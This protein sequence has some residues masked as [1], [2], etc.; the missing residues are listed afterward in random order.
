M[1]RGAGLVV[2]SCRGG[3]EAELVIGRSGVGGGK[4][5]GAWREGR[6]M[7]GGLAPALGCGLSVW[8]SA[9][10]RYKRSI[11]GRLWE[12]LVRWLSARI[13]NSR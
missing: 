7:I 2:R 4:P 3:H 12:G 11:N 9:A 13:A 10:F 8:Y 1:G 5:F 6:G